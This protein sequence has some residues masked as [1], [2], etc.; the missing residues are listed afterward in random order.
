MRFKL[1]V[2][3]LQKMVL[4]TAGPY[5]RV[6]HVKDSNRAIWIAPQTTVHPLPVRPH[7]TVMVWQAILIQLCLNA[8]FLSLLLLWPSCTL[9]VPER[10]A[11]QCTGDLLLPASCAEFSYYC[12]SS[13]H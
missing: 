13:E 3:T 5:S 8:Y 2:F 4:L 9:S 10:E 7:R 1:K 12:S 6:I 11:P